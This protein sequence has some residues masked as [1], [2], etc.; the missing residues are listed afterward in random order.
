MTSAK[1][2][3]TRIIS[4]F[5][6]LMRLRQLDIPIFI[7]NSARHAPRRI[8]AASVETQDNPVLIQ[9]SSRTRWFATVELTL[10]GQ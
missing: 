3:V 10:C 8:V 2:E 7:H 1:A 5:F 9:L 6:L 4:F